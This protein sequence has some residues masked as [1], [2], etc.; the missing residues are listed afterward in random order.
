M[1]FSEQRRLSGGFINQ[2]APSQI[3]S[4][5]TSAL[6]PMNTFQKREGFIPSQKLKN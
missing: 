5:R 6:T 3:E 4:D 1:K 2:G